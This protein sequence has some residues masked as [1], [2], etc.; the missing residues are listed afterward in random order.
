[1][2]HG[3]NGSTLERET[4]EIPLP[5]MDISDVCWKN[6]DG[7]NQ[8]LRRNAPRHEDRIIRDKVDYEYEQFVLNFYFQDLMPIETPVGS[9]LFDRSGQHKVTSKKFKEELSAENLKIREKLTKTK[10]KI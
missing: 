9:V 2:G 8:L 1:M 7:Q 6:P 10:V 3:W 4:T 5:H